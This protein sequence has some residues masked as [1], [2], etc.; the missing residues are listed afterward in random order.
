MHRTREESENSQFLKISAALKKVVQND[1]NDR[2]DLS[3]FKR[4]TNNSIET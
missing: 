1:S 3:I 2:H 4:I